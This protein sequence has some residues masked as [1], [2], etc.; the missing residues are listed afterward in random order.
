MAKEKK[1]NS[2]ERD[3]SLKR[4]SGV[5]SNL[6]YLF[7]IKEMKGGPETENSLKVLSEGNLR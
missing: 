3:L 7:I 4:M 5:T 6:I 2:V 1:K